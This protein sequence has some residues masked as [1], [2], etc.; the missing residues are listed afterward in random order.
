M[1]QRM[2]IAL[3]TMVATVGIAAMAAPAQA[4]FEFADRV[5][6]V[7]GGTTTASVRFSAA[8]NGQPG[9]PFTGLDEAAY[10]AQI[11]AT[12]GLQIP[13][14]YAAPGGRSLI[15]L[16]DVAAA[17][18]IQTTFLSF[19]FDAP[20]EN[21]PNTYGASFDSQ[22]PY[23]LVIQLGAVSGAFTI[24]DISFDLVGGGT[25]TEFQ[26]GNVVDATNSFDRLLITIPDNMPILTTDRYAT[27]VNIEFSW[28][29]MQGSFLE[30]DAVA[31]PEPGSMA[32][33]GLGALGLVAHRRRRRRKAATADADA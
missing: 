4:Q 29:G 8:N 2:K 32:L 27:A 6:I 26:Y 3:V 31:N 24:G 12:M 1:T 22:A 9:T 21:G 10:N 30:V 20:F 17:V 19:H 25:T 7:A 13:D 11:A 5:N 28:V 18:S 16:S 23:D 14:G 33:F 15:T